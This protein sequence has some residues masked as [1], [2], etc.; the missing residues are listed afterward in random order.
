MN[1]AKNNWNLD[2][3]DAVPAGLTDQGFGAEVRWEIDQL[4]LVLGRTYR[5]YF[6]VH[7]GD[8]NKAGGDV[9]QGCTTLNMGGQVECGGTNVLGALGDFV[10]RDLDGDGLQNPDEPGVTN[11]TVHLT[12]CS[13]IMLRA[14]TTDATGHYLF[15]GLAAGSYRVKFMPPAGLIFTTAN[16][17]NDALDSDADPASGLTGCYL[18]AAGE[19]NRTV[20]AGLVGGPPP[21]LRLIKTAD[22]VQTVAGGSVTYRYVVENTG[23]NTLT[24]IVVTDDNGTPGFPA[25]DFTVGSIPTLAPQETATAL[26]K[27]IRMPTPL[28]LADGNGVVSPSGMILTE[29]LPNGDIKATFIQST[30]VND[31]TYGANA[32]GWGSKGHTFG[33]LTGSD[34]AVWS[35]RNGSGTVVLSFNQDYL[36][37]SAAFPSGFGT[38][39]VAGGEGSM[40]VGSAAHVLAVGTS[41]TDNLNKQPFL[42]GK[43]QYIVNSPALNDP[44]SAQ[45]EYR[46]IYTVT[47]SRNAF[48]VAG[49]GKAMIT[50]QHN[51]P[52]KLPFVRGPI[53]TVCDACITNLATATATAGGLTQTATAAARVCLTG[54]SSPA[55]GG[56]GG[57]L[58]SPW[59][60]QDIG[61][62]EAA[63]SAG[64][65][66]DTCTVAGSGK[67]I[68]GS[69]DEFRY[70]YQT[71]SGDCAIVA[72]VLSVQNTDKGAKAGVMIRESLNDNS[73][74]AGVFVTP[75]NGIEFR[76][77]A[78]TGG[79]TSTKSAGGF[80]APCWVKVVRSGNML[81]G[82]H[83]ADGA[84]W[85]S[86]GSVTLNMSANVNLGLGVNSHK[87]GTLS[88]G[89]FNNVTPT[90]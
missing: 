27:T 81:T 67:D 13:G 34:K 79:N 32:I 7:D 71:A 60:S 54:G 9:G 59:Q 68:G 40:I 14:T 1:P 28:C 57:S 83:S 5:L 47:V 20:D 64:M 78:S 80:Q 84:T 90:P 87:D 74:H 76:T 70:V 10:W 88:T 22:P 61:G 62:V 53:P 50:D 18:L 2:G 66:G 25:D 75:G 31:N 43:A 33:N 44:N 23:S 12:D 48:G 30:A 69:K 52:T 51:S 38:L 36:T 19:T 49:F 85:T 29:I 63:G 56:G 3:G 11:V 17:G 41:L 86:M 8:Q 46:M 6:M 58:P 4:P 82:Y 35:F 72:K 37:A 73:A 42:A 45:W 77:R 21:S 15:G 26:D 16:T 39:G 24:N 55:G 89:T 65:A